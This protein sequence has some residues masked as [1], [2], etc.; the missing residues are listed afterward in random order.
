MAKHVGTCRV[1]VL[2]LPLIYGVI[3][4]GLPLSQIRLRGLGRTYIAQ[5]VQEGYDRP[6]TISELPPGKLE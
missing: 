5:P 6:E 2:P 1:P 4:E 3:Q